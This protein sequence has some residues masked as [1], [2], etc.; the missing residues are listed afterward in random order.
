[1]PTLRN[2]RAIFRAREI[3]LDS[4]RESG[5]A[6]LKKRQVSDIFISV[7]DASFASPACPS[8][9][10]RRPSLFAPFGELTGTALVSDAC[11]V[12]L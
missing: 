10:T 2:F 1:M 5:R 11:G 12:Q 9:V 8:P 6:L 3:G 7:L 4:L